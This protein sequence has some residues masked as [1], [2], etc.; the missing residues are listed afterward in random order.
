MWCLD[1]NRIRRGRNQS[2]VIAVTHKRKSPLRASSA[3]SCRLP[4]ALAY[5]LRS[6]IHGL[7]VIEVKQDI[8]T[9]V[10]QFI[11]VAVAT[12]DVGVAV[13]WVVQR[14]RVSGSIYCGTG[15]VQVLTAKPTQEIEVI[16]APK[17]SPK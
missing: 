5:S 6:K 7:K 16:N 10:L 11:V 14:Y 13:E 12:V 15:L 3:G 17:A 8:V 1:C 2:D 4:N 9:V